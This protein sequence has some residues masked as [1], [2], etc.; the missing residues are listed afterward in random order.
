MF[1]FINSWFFVG[2]VLLLA[3]YLKARLSSLK[4]ANELLDFQLKYSLI[5]IEDDYVP[6]E[7]R[8][9]CE[10]LVYISDR[11]FVIYKIF[12]HGLLGK[13]RKPDDNALKSS[14]NLF[15][16]VSKLND[17]QRDYFNK[18]FTSCVF[19]ITF[20]SVILGGFV[21]R[22]MLFA[23]DSSVEVKEK[24]AADFYDDDNYVPHA[25]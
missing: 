19:G 5:L 18:A 25:A 4:N 12:F 14:K 8:D 16:A 1:D 21:R 13:F 23:L 20:R 7:I 11:K 24:L 22:V 9:F 15:E 6:E 10:K 3:F 2:L 17:E